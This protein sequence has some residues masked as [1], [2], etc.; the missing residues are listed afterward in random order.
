VDVTSPRAERRPLARGGLGAWVDAVHAMAEA[1]LRFR[2]GRG[3]GRL[4][5][6]LL[7]PYAL[8]GVYLIL[9]TFVLHRAGPAPGLSL[10]CSVVPFQLVIATV[11]NATGAIHARKSIILNMRF[12]RTLIPIATVLTEIAAFAAS[13]SLIV[14]MM[15]VYRVTPTVHILWFPVVLA[16]TV[17]VALGFAFPAAIFGLWFRE[18]RNLALSVVRTL[19]FVAPGLVPLSNTGGTAYQIL[20]LNPM[21]GLFESYRAIFVFHRSP[22]AWELL[23]PSLFALVLLAI[24]IPLYRAEQGQFAKVVE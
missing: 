15:I 13:L 16:V 9:V 18:L 8:V 6:W 2:Y 20:K 21:T 14:V 22:H 7:D 24:G 5:K 3:S 1:D 23:Y 11:T 17:L 12:D 19:Y 10:A 4:L